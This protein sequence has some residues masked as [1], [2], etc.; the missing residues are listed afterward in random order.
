MVFLL[1]PLFSYQGSPV[2]YDEVEKLEIGDSVNLKSKYYFTNYLTTGLDLPNTLMYQSEGMNGVPFNKYPNLGN[3]NGLNT[4]KEIF[5]YKNGLY[6]RIQVDSMIYST[7]NHFKS[8]IWNVQ[9]AWSFEGM[10][11]IVWVDNPDPYMQTPMMNS[12][13]A[14]NAYQSF[15]ESLVAKENYSKAY[16]DNDGYS[17][18]AVFKTIDST[19][20]NLKK[21]V[22]TASNGDTLRMYFTYVSDFAE[23]TSSNPINFEFYNLQ[24]A[25][26]VGLPVEIISTRKSPGSNEMV[27]SADLYF[28]DTARLKKHLKINKDIQFAS[29]TK[30][31]LNDTGFF[32]DSNYEVENEVT[33]FD[34]LYNPAQIKLR[35]KRQS[36]I[37]DNDRIMAVA[38]NTDIHDLAATS[39]ETNAK[40]RWSYSK[41]PVVDYS[42][43]TGKNVYNL[44]SSSISCSGMQSNKAYTISYWSKTGS[45][46]VN[47][48]S[49]SA[50]RVTNGWTYYEHQVSNPSAGIITISGSEKID[51]LRL[52][53]TGILMT[54]YTY[55]PLLG[56]LSQCGPNNT[57][58]YYEYDGMGRLSLIRDQDKN[59]IKKICY[60]LTGQVEN[61]SLY[62]NIHQTATYTK[63]NCGIDSIGNSIS[64]T[65][66]SNT[67]YAGSQTAADSLAQ[68]FLNANG[69]SY[70]NTHGSCTYH[71]CDGT[72]CPGPSHKCINGACVEGGIKILSSGKNKFD[73]G[74]KCT[75]VYC[76]PDGTFSSIQT[77]LNSPVACSPI[78]VCTY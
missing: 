50:L 76:F 17:E 38:L 47:S 31:Y 2:A 5:N 20:G 11:W 21:V 46:S 13:P 26:L 29:M 72:V 53:P 19:N 71:L 40:G 62:G 48:T 57:I 30:A 75:F 77:I 51:E 33:V 4:K 63:N 34:S 56:M 7:L 68:A 73:V 6:K 58:S 22:T 24:Q 14:L 37:W 70:A 41:H 66:L 59:V 45:K 54:T 52:R 60:S 69:Q 65:V 16:D 23:T 12:S 10:A 55:E 78:G 64:D 35:D 36:I 43:I 27:E 1:H 32:Y 39:F 49:G 8:Y 28:Y 61:C 3:F 67:Y 74:W 15:H 9:A 18:Q 42:A 25:N 44:D